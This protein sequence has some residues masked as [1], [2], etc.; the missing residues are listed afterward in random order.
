M[1]DPNESPAVGPE[2]F[3]L[4]DEACAAVARI[5]EF[6]HRLSGDGGEPVQSSPDRG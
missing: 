3:E 6:L 4:P 2:P 1:S 5:L